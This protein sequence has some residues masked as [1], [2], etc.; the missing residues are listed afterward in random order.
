MHYDDVDAAD[1]ALKFPRVLAGYK[2]I[3]SINLRSGL[4]GRGQAR[5]MSLRADWVNRPANPV[6]PSFLGRRQ[7]H[8]ARARRLVGVKSCGV[9]GLRAAARARQ[10]LSA[11]SLSPRLG[12]LR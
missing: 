6:K 12:S 10:S 7:V 11:R 5:A 9:G 1:C 2:I 3:E 8:A 4:L